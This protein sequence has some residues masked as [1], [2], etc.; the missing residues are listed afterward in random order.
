MAG[1]LQQMADSCSHHAETDDGK[2]IRVL[3]LH[4]S[5]KKGLP[6]A[7]DLCQTV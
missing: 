3:S 1:I 2:I 5:N 4:S 7:E 6:R